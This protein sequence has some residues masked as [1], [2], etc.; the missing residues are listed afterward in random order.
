MPLE[1]RTI[2]Y[3][4]QRVQE[5]RIPNINRGRLDQ[6]FADVC[7]PRFRHTHHQCASRCVKVTLDGGMRLTQGATNLRTVPDATGIV[8]SHGPE[9]S[10]RARWHADPQ[11]DQIAFKKRSNEVLAPGSTV[12]LRA[13]KE[14]ARKATAQPESIEIRTIKLC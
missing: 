13:R 11:L 5:P 14:R 8:C 2:A 3:T 10:H 6:P 12:S 7:G 4:E 9:S 1:L